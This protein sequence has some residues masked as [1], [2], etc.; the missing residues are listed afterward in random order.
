MNELAEGQLDLAWDKFRQVPM[1]AAVMDNLYN[2]ALDFERKR[3]H[4][5]AV[6]VYEHIASADAGYKAYM[7]YQCYTCHGT[8]G[9][10]ASRGGHLGL[11][12]QRRDQRDR[13]EDVPA[14]EKGESESEEEQ[15]DQAAGRIRSG[16]WSEVWK[17]CQCARSIV[18]RAV[19]TSLLV[20]VYD[21]AG[22]FLRRVATGGAL[23][24][25]WGLALAPA[26]RNQ[27]VR[28]RRRGRGVSSSHGGTA[29]LEPGHAEVGLRA[30]VR[31]RRRGR[32]AP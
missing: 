16:A 1:S 11:L 10:G 19:C 7:K 25:P 32:R 2:L 9:H 5:K 20:D 23:N 26:G 24:A 27:G 29:S 18:A 12:E 13:V 30:R 17:F 21:T 31:N 3:Q 6:A 8:V 28:V 4:N 14:K 22:H 15:R